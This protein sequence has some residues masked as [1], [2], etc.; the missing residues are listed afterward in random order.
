MNFTGVD[1]AFTMYVPTDVWFW[2]VLGVIAWYIFAAWAMRKWCGFCMQDASEPFPALLWC[3]S[4][5]VLPLWLA[6]IYITTSK[7]E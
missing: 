1:V 3:L 7:K 6:Q 5:V 2:S 4:P